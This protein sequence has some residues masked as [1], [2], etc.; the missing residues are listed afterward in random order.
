MSNEVYFRFFLLKERW[1]RKR[2]A[3]H[4]SIANATGDCLLIQDADLEHKHIEYNI[5]LKPIPDGH[6]DIVYS[7]R[8]MGGNTHRTIFF[9]DPI[10]NAVLIFFNN[11]LSNQNLTDM[12]T[13]YKLFKTPDYQTG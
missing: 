10:G 12:E 13:C 6:A 2:D 5:L 11:M 9:W 8:F 3:I 1:N 4:T 7:S